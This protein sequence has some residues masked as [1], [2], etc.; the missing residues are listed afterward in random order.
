MDEAPP[1]GI[2]R[3]SLLTLGFGCFFS[4]TIS[5]AGSIFFITNG[6][7]EDG[8][9]RIQNRVR[10][11]EP[12][13]LFRNL[14]NGKFE[15]VTAAMGARICIA[16]SGA[17]RGLRRHRQRRRARHCDL[18]QRRPRRISSTT[19]ARRITACAS[20]LWE[21]VRIATESAQSLSWPPGSDTQTQMLRSGSSY[22]SSSELVLTFGLGAREQADTIEV[23]WPSGKSDRLTNVHADQI[24]TIKEG[25]G[26]SAAQPLRRK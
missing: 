10:Y 7:I 25:S 9:E 5:T 3:A 11:A 23:R 13:H 12:P 2:G 14:G 6:H 8:I 1:I 19:P 26:Q 4:I 15:E 16:A 17:W 21:R 22:L 24:I 18:D 20:S